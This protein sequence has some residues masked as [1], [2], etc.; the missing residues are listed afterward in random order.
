M[1]P[2][3]YLTA[4]DTQA[5]LANGKTT[6]EQILHD[7]RDRF[8]ERDHEVKAWVCVDHQAAAVATKTNKGPLEGVVIGIKDIISAFQPEISQTALA[9]LTT[10]YQGLPNSTWLT[11]LQRITTWSRRC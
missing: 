3:N 4:T 9:V 7:H 1:V 11:H 5:L 6:I 10:R 8:E 2:T